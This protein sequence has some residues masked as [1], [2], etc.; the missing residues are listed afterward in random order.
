M[1]ARLETREDNAE[2]FHQSLLGS[3]WNRWECEKGGGFDWV[4]DRVVE[5]KWKGVAA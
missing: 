1:K 2:N 5:G 3:E 4:T